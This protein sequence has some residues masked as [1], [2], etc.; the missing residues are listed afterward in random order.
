MLRAIFALGTLVLLYPSGSLYG[1]NVGSWRS[2]PPNSQ[3]IIHDEKGRRL[4]WDDNG[5]VVGRYSYHTRKYTAVLP[6]EQRIS[7][8]EVETNGRSLARVRK[9]E[10]FD[11][12]ATAELLWSVDETTDGKADPRMK[13]GNRRGIERPRSSTMERVEQGEQEER[14]VQEEPAEVG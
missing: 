2:S 10:P 7:A 12:R 14:G 11:E 1:Q 6:G 9:E 4:F 8:P 13:I 5:Q 3:A